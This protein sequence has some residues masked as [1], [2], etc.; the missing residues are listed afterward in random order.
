[1]DKWAIVTTY[2]DPCDQGSFMFNCTFWGQK[3]GQSGNR[4]LMERH[5]ASFLRI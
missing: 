4:N 1:M 3:R 5:E 2:K